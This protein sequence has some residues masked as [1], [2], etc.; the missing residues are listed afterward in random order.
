V[1]KVD[2]RDTETVTDAVI[3][4]ALAVPVLRYAVAFQQAEPALNLWRWQVDISPIT[5]LAFGISY[6]FA[7]Y[8]GVREAMA[9]KRRGSKRWWWPLAGSAVQTIVGALIVVPVLV[10]NINGTPLNEL[11][12]WLSGVPL[13]LDTAT[14]LSFATISLSL[15]VQVKPR[16]PIVK[17]ACSVCSKKF[18][19]DDLNADKMCSSC[20]KSAKGET[21][22]LPLSLS[23]KVLERDEWMCYYCGEDLREVPAGKRHI[24]HFVPKSKDGQ[25]IDENLVT[26][27]ARC[28]LSKNDRMPNE[29]EV[30]QFSQ[31][32]RAK[33]AGADRKTQILELGLPNNGNEPLRQKDI[34]S[35]LRTSQGY[36]SSILKEAR[37][38]AR[39]LVQ[40]RGVTEA[41][42]EGENGK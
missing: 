41:V 19:Q 31:Y 18:K 37:E 17:I 7:A 40:K 23:L 33:S 39:N 2:K 24:D 27:C 25:D 14:L 15:A 28:N 42:T 10:S 16:E 12:N 20:E 36:V 3:I 35:I 30:W 4:A 21:H 9:A 5:G 34:A 38:A 1:G 26:S 13:M 29:I 11:P 6:E 22:H 32:L 8:I